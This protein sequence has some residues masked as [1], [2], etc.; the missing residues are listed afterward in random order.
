MSVKPRTN[1]QLGATWRFNIVVSL[2]AVMAGMLVWRILEL[3]VLDTDRGYEFLQDQGDARTLRAET[4]PAYRGVIS[5]RNG[6]PLAVSTPVASVWINPKKLKDDVSRWSELALALD[7]PLSQIQQKV[8]N[9]SQRSFAYLLR[10]MSPRSAAEVMALKIKGVN[11]QR[12]YKRYYPAGEVAAHVVGFANIDDKGQEGME[13]AYDNWLNGDPGK[14]HVLKDLHGNIF[15]DVNKGFEAKPGKGLSLSLDMRLQHLAYRELKAALA[16]I[17]AK[18]GSVVV[19]DSASGEV[20]AM[21]N[22][23]AFNPNNRRFLKSSDLRNRAMT[24]MFEPGSTVKPLTVVAALESGKYLPDS[25]IDTNPGHI[26][27]GKKTILDPVNYGVID[28]TKLLTK[29]SQVGTSKLALDLDEQLIWSVFHRFG[30]GV[31]TGS[32]FPGE[33]SGLLPNKS[34]WLP[35][36][37]ANFAFGYGLTVTPLQLAQA[38]S[39][40]ANGGLLRPVTLL[41]NSELSGKDDSLTERVIDETISQQ[42]VE[43]LK[44]VTLKGGTATS[45][46]IASYSVAGKTGTTH[47]VGKR[48]YDD[49]RY[50]AVFAGLAPASNPR[51]VAVVMIDEPDLKNYHGG[52]AAAPVFS[53]IVGEALRLMDVVPDLVPAGNIVDTKNLSK[54]MYGSI[55]ERGESA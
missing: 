35:I 49:N 51:L 9:N 50:T 34:K 45:A 43:M 27:I 33:S 32:G 44:T 1:T 21:V 13:L 5:D 47:K 12:E 18:S 53:K 39:V 17:N 29:S 25:L 36:E 37:R 20:L 40:F 26:K 10:H 2:M 23:P 28:V 42:I 16:R 3:Q 14:R 30:L 54:R 4:I 48:G 19:L 24:D 6:E 38:Y 8:K 31:S 15:R 11:V 52:E 22:Q 55:V 7:M 46:Q 41:H